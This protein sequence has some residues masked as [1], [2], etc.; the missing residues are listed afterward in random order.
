MCVWVCANVSVGTQGGQ[1]REPDSL[2]LVLEVVVSCPVW[3]LGTELWFSVRAA[4]AINH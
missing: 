1:E 2:E 4:D 3:M